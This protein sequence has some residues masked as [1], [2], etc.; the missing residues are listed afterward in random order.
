MSYGYL[1]VPFYLTFIT[2]SRL[3]VYRFDSC[4]CFM[5][6]LLSVICM[7]VVVGADVGDDDSGLLV[8]I[9]GGVAPLGA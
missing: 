5:R 4:S 7:A 2:S 8:E 1:K 6:Q 3:V 9:C